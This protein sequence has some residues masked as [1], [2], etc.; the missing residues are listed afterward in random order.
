MKTILYFTVSTTFNIVLGIIDFPISF[1][2]F[3]A[4]CMHDM[5]WDPDNWN[6]I[7]REALERQWKN[8]VEATKVKNV[9]GNNTLL[10]PSQERER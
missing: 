8:S 2:L 9:S 5:C 1:I 4:R 7:F 10:R 6:W 3:V